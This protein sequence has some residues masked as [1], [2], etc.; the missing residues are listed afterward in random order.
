VV[1][2][3]RPAGDVVPEALAWAEELSR[4]A[5]ACAGGG[6]D[7]GAGRGGGGAGFVL[8]RELLLGLYRT[9][10]GVDGV[11]AFA[12]KRKAEFGGR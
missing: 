8:E 11:R 2:R 3:V 9:V 12:E 7:G 6:E 5:A 10:D 4:R 1:N